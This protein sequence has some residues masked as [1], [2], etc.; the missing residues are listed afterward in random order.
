[1]SRLSATQCALPGG[2]SIG[3]SVCAK[4]SYATDSW[5]TLAQTIY[6]LTKLGRCCCHLSEAAQ[7]KHLGKA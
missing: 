7:Q 1:M 3:F 6:G 5:Q 4:L 2:D